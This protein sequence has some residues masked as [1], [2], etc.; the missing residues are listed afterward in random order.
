MTFQKKLLTPIQISHEIET[1]C[2]NARGPD[3]IKTR[4]RTWA[5][6]FAEQ[7]PS[8]RWGLILERTLSD[9]IVLYLAN[10]GFQRGHDGDPDAVELRDLGGGV[11]ILAVA[12][13]LI[14]SAPTAEQQQDLQL[15]WEKE[16]KRQLEQIISL[17]FD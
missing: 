11:A 10:T 3:T 6:D 15:H 14:S 2:L 16:L 5:A 12:R 13:S 7:T 8:R 4:L 9:L 17:M 1:V